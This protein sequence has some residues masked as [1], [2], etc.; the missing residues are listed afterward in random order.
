M[1]ALVRRESALA[2]R[3]RPSALTIDRCLRS[4][5]V[6]YHTGEAGSRGRRAMATRQAASLPGPVPVFAPRPLRR[7]PGAFTVVHLVAAELVLAGLVPLAL[8]RSALTVALAAVAVV[9]LLVFFGRGGGRWW[10]QAIGV[11][12]RL[13][14]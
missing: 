8:R 4:T 9:V 12:W 5:A 2:L 11:R 1:P 7:R 14:A 3:D 6:S 10:Y 13:S